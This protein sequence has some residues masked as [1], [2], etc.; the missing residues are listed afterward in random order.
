MSRSLV[1]SSSSSTLGSVSSSRSS[2]KRRRSPPDRSPRRA[3]SRSPVKPNR[4]SIEVAVTSP[5]TVR[6]TRRIDSTVA[7]HPGLG[8]ELVDVLGEVLER[9]GPAVLDP[10]GHRRQLPGE[11]RE[12]RR[13]A[14]AVDADDTDPVP[15]PDPPGGVVQQRALAAHQVDVLDVDHV[16]AQPL[17]GEPL[18]LEPVARRR[19]VLDQ[20]VRGLDPELRL[21]RPGRRSPA[22]PGELLADQVLPAGLGRGRLALPLRLGQDVRRVPAVVRVD[23][24]ARAPPTWTGRPRRGTTGRGS[25]RPARRPGS[26]RWSASQATASTSRWL[27]G[28]SSTIRSCPPSSSAASEQRRRSPPDSAGDRAVEG[29]AGQQHLDDLAGPRVGRPLVVGPVRRARP[30]APSGVSSRSSPWWR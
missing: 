19:H 28:S 5:S 10:P 25:P 15:R 11:E 13:L 26:A 18:Q 24:T 9:D 1:G 20:R 14:G 2:W 27:V 4:S 3:V 6:V 30:R 8:V 16:L 7:Q 23:L 12:H 17:G 22:Q 21:R 29:D